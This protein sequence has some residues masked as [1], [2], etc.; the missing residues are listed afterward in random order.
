M[1]LL[2]TEDCVIVLQVLLALVLIEML[3]FVN[4]PLC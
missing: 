2:N 4:W 3:S 1:S